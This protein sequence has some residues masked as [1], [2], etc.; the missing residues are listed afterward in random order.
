MITHC[1]KLC[2]IRW[3]IG[4]YLLVCSCN[5]S[6]I[7]GFSSHGFRQWQEMRE[8]FCFNSQSSM[9]VMVKKCHLGTGPPVALLQGW[10]GEDTV[11]CC[12][13]G[14]MHYMRSC[15]LLATLLKHVCRLTL[16]LSFYM[17]DGTNN[18]RTVLRKRW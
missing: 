17:T 16:V 7:R 13:A 12:P 18:F 1:V 14:K 15:L 11:P 3:L 10:G 4:G 5:S 6:Y 9:K 8:V 2:C